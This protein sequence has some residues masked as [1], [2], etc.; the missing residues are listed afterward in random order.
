MPTSLPASLNCQKRDLTAKT[1][2]SKQSP[3]EHH[4]DITAASTPKDQGHDDS[5]I[6]PGRADV[7]CGRNLTGRVWRYAVGS[8]I[9]QY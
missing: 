5:E 6:M 4:P 9:A 3:P 8:V 1:N 7:K 2:E